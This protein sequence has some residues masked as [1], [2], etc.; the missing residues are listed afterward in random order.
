MLLITL[1][2]I[3]LTLMICAYTFKRPAVSVAGGVLWLL[4]GLWSLSISTVTW[5]IYYDLFI[6]GIGLFIMGLVEAMSLR[7]KVQ[8]ESVF[9]DYWDRAK[10]EYEQKQAE[11][12]ERLQ[13]LKNVM[14]NKKRKSSVLDE[15]GE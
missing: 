14:G 9:E 7:P 4:F 1:A 3:A 8:D 2:L 10:K 11:Q 15:L 13:Q 6:V 12:N 5:D